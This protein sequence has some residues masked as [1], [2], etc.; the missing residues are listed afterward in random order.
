MPKKKTH[1]DMCKIM[2]KLDN[3]IRTLDDTQF[4]IVGFVRDK[5]KNGSDQCVYFGPEYKE[6]VMTVLP[7]SIFPR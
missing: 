1:M 6:T 3:L 7:I 2:A 5:G 4:Q